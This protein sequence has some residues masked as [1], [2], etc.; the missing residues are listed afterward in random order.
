MRNI[1][2]HLNKKSVSPI[3]H[4]AF[5]VSCLQVR[6]WRDWTHSGLKTPTF[7][8]RPRTFIQLLTNASEPSNVKH[9]ATRLSPGQDASLLCCTICQTPI[10]RVQTFQVGLFF[11]DAACHSEY[12]IPCC[13]CSFLPWFTSYPALLHIVIVILPV[14]FLLL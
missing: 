6:K 10:C 14:V 12:L 7:L 2:L 3:L 4:E 9:L 1:L 13:L 8:S 5:P 11:L